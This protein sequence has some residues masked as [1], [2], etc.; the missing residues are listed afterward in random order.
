MGT[1]FGVHPIVPRKKGW[2]KILRKRIPEEAMLRRPDVSRHV[3]D[4]TRGGEWFIV[5]V[6]PSYNK[7]SEPSLQEMGGPPKIGGKPPQIIH[8][9]RVGTIIFTIHFGVALFLATP[10]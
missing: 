4:A 7:K 6:C 2:K 8:F 3:K 9:N 5:N 10:K 1:L